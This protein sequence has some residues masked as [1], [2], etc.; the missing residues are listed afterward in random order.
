[1]NKYQMDLS[2]HHSCGC[3]WFWLFQL[4]TLVFT[5]PAIVVTFLR[6]LLCPFTLHLTS[7]GSVCCSYLQCSDVVTSHFG[8]KGRLVSIPMVDRDRI[9]LLLFSFT[10]LLLWVQKM[11]SY[12]YQR[13]PCKLLSWRGLVTHVKLNSFMSFRASSPLLFR[14]FAKI[15]PGI[16]L[17]PNLHLTNC[18]LIHNI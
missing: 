7:T 9:F 10:L 17:T 18:L 15:F 13:P 16:S 2:S 8:W 4:W 5:M 14:Q 3:F 11:H 1:M 12:Q 6:D